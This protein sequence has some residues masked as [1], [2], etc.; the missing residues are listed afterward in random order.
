MCGILGQIWNFGIWEYEARVL[1]RSPEIATGRVYRLSLHGLL[2]YQTAREHSIYWGI[3]AWSSWIFYIGW[4]MALIHI[5][6]SGEL[7]RFLKF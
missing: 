7:K 4:A 6:K 5:W 2:V 1:P 3:E